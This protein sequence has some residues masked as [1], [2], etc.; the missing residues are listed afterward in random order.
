MSNSTQL[1]KHGSH[2][3]WPEFTAYSSPK[4]VVGTSQF[5]ILDTAQYLR[6]DNRLWKEFQQ[7]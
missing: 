7:L 3:F 5:K 4:A 1:F 2:S 6:N